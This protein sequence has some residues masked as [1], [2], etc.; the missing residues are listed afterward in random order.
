MKAMVGQP[1]QRIQ[2]GVPLFSPRQLIHSLSEPSGQSTPHQR[3]PKNTI[4]SSTKGHQSPQNRNW[5]NTVMLS[6]MRA[7]DGGSER[8]AGTSSRIR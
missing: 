4:D 1:L 7:S 8:T 2:R 3:R 6:S 5:A